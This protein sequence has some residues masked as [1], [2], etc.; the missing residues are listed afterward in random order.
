[1]RE[2]VFATNNAHKVEEVQAIIGNLFTL[3][4]LADIGCDVDIPETGDTFQDNAAQ[5]SQYL[6]EHYAVD[7][8]ADD[9]GLVVEA[10]GGEPGVYSARYSGSRDMEA[11]LDLLIK[12]MQGLSNRRAYFITVISL[13]LDG[14]HYFF[15]GRVEG[16]LLNERKGGK[17]F[18]YDPIFVPD[19]YHQTF[20][21]MDMQEKTTISHRTR[22]VQQMAAFLQNYQA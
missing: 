5:K 21:E 9:S 7:C 16:Q 14:Q 20:A 13:R 2:L 18:G 15:E 3:K 19:G 4:T 17:G 11:N 12:R 22:A 10:L 6:L 8:F 1:M